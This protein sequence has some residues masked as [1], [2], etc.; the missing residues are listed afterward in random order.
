MERFH[1][2]TMNADLSRETWS[3]SV[4]EVKADFLLAINANRK[5]RDAKLDAS[6]AELLHAL[7][8]E[9]TGAVAITGSTWLINA[10]MQL[11]ALFRLVVDHL[12]IAHHA[13]T[14]IQLQ[15][16]DGLAF[17]PEAGAVYEIFAD[18]DA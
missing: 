8:R 1:I 18:R 7:K 17:D 14:L 16:G 15:S 4:A 10:K 13:Y 11:E 12:G 9:T 5:G 2:G 3:A 6:Y